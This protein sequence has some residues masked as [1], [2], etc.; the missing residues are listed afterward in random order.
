MHPLCALLVL[1][2]AATPA[3]AETVMAADYR[4]LLAELDARVDFERLPPRPEPG[5]N[6]DVPLY[7]SGAWVG[8]RFIGQAASATDA[9]HDAVTGAP[10]GPWLRIAGGAPGRNLSVAWH[11]GFGSNA[12]FPLGPAGFPA[13]PARGEGAAAILFDTDQPAVGFRI[14]TDYPAPLGSPGAVQGAIDVTLYAR[15][16]QLL[17][18]FT[19]NPGPGI[20]EF[21]YRIAGDGPAIAGMLVVN[22][23]PG[24]IAMDDI[25]FAMP[26]PLG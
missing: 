3:A 11:R 16:G 18:R 17:G 4:K 7:S 23:D 20:S 10:E 15:D 19:H 21:G 26:R 25:I 13:L 12:L 22:T 2:L 14:H 24:G 1:G 6:L 8:E 9:G 5:F